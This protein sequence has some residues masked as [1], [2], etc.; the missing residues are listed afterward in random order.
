MLAADFVRVAVHD[1]SDL[2]TGALLSRFNAREKGLVSMV[3]EVASSEV[4]SQHFCNLL[5]AFELFHF[6]V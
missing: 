2:E 5:T 4:H 1:T 3:T 6:S